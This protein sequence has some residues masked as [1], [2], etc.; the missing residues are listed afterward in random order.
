MR[1]AMVTDSYFPTRDGVVTVVSLLEKGLREMGHEVTVVAPDPGEAHRLEGVRYFP[2][3]EFRQYPGYYVPVFPSNKVQVLEEIAPDVI[4]I[5]GIAVMAVKALIAARALGIP[6]VATFHTMVDRAMD[7]YSP[8]RFSPE[9]RDRLVWTYVRNY[10]KRPYAVV[11]PSESA[12]EAVLSKGV[13][14]KRYEVIP[15]GVDTSRFNPDVPGREEI[16]ERYGL[17]GKRV[18]VNVSRV[19]FEKKIDL[20]IDA[21]KLMPEDCALMVVGKGPALEDLKARARESG[22]GDRIVF[23]GFVQDAEL[24][25]HIA[26]GDVAVSASEFE[27]QGLAILESM[28]CGL[29]AACA[30][31][32]GYRD[33]VVEGVNGHF[34]GS[35]PESC[36]EAVAKCLLDRENLSRGAVDTA[37][38]HSYT[39]A[40]ERTAALYADAVKGVR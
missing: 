12:A 10:L 34:F 29:P 39:G 11:F 18:L 15:M 6:T 28:A 14:P 9:T 40:V 30:M 19:A 5:H 26:A 7:F 35:T 2:A 4:H 21:L 31:A 1:I 23:T 25:A 17:A 3:K 22:V 8:I 16:R 13:R 33:F 37:R 36:A 38:A 27:T 24:L 20:L 32:E